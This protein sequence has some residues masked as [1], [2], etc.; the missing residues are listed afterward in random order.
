VDWSWIMVLQLFEDRVE[1]ITVKVY[2][3]LS[4]G[5]IQPW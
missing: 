5:C 3:S 1:I 2:L 4:L